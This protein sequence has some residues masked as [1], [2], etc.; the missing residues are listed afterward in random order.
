MATCGSVD[1]LV[2]N[3]GV[4]DQIGLT[5][6]YIYNYFGTHYMAYA[7]QTLMPFID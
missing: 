5:G 7:L 6:N 4:Y 1:V 2:N 3:A